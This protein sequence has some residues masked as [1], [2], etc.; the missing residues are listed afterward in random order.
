MKLLGCPGI[1]KGSADRSTLAVMIPAMAATRGRGSGPQRSVSGATRPHREPP[2]WIPLAAVTAVPITLVAAGVGGLF[3]TWLAAGAL[4]LGLT[5]TAILVGWWMV[6]PSLSS[7]SKLLA[8]AASFG[9]VLT[10][11]IVGI[12]RL[13]GG[14]NGLETP[15]STSTTLLATSTTTSSAPATTK[16]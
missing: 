1:G 13:A 2:P 6:E 8:V 16:P 7:F 9:L 10:A 12:T 14:P 4:I 11:A 15:S 5:L 3:A